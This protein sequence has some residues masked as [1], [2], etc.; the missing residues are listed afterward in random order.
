[1]EG[2]YVTLNPDPYKVSE[3]IQGMALELMCKP[4]K[5]YN[6][7]LVMTHSLREQ[8]MESLFAKDILSKM[9][10]LKQEVELVNQENEQLKELLESN[11][12]DAGE[13]K[14]NV[15]NFRKDFQLK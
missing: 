14:S 11:I 4:F 5:F 15:E 13:S 1:M 6:F 3:E 12:N 2:R 9:T 8:I 10:D 7:N